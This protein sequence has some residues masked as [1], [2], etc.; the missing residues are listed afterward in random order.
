MVMIERVMVGTPR[1][2]VGGEMSAIWKEPVT[3]P[4]Q[5]GE[6]GLDGD[7][8]V[9][10]THGGPEKALFHYA[11][12]H[13]LMWAERFPSA[14]QAAGMTATDAGSG[15]A[16]IPTRT[17]FGENI[18]TF[19]M[20]EKD[21]CLGDRYRIGETVVVEVTQ[22]RQPCWKLGFTA[23][24]VEVPVLMQETA[25]TGWYYRVVTPGPVAPRDPIRL[26]SRPL[27]LWTLSRMIWGFY[28]TPGDRTFL[29]ELES[30]SQLST[31]WRAIV[32]TRLS[33]GTVEDWNGRLYR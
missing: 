31:E 27:P 10:H 5:L 18:V 28:G 26:E 8:Q 12:E 1:E 7:R 20:T 13:Y 16:A 6:L 23:G 19:G 22:P 11:G 29:E 9:Y 2:L 3:G 30:L 33:T 4:V 32:E 17:L 14:R 21:V 25:T 24:A 15:R